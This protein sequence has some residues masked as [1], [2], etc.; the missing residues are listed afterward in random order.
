MPVHF[1]AGAHLRSAGATFVVKEYRRM[2]D[3]K[4]LINFGWVAYV[5]VW[6]LLL[7]NIV[8]DWLTL[9]WISPLSIMMLITLAGG[10]LYQRWRGEPMIKLEGAG[11]RFLITL[12]FVL[13]FMV[14]ILGRI[15]WSVLS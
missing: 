10:A 1:I 4:M 3:K 13:A 12:V 8:N 15:V 14:V 7:A 9:Q 11:Q 2:L 6:A 5:L